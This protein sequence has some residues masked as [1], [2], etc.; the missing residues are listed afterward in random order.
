VDDYGFGLQG[1]KIPSIL[2]QKGKR[3]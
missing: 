2:R 1:T 3:G